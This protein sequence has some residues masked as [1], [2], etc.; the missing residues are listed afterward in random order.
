M[1]ANQLLFKDVGAKTL[2]HSPEG[3]GIL[4]DLHEATK[5][6]VQWIK[7]PTFEELMDRRTVEEEVP[8]E[9]TF[10]E[11][12]D[13]PYVALHTSGTTGHP[14][15]VVDINLSILDDEAYSSR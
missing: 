6:S 12:K 15:Y 7:T 13:K 5:D 2:F 11:L 14:K 8:F 10:D 1:P 4:S 9:Y 3:F